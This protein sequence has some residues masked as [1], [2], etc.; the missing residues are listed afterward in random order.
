MR[1]LLLRPALRRPLTSVLLLTSWLAACGPDLQPNPDDVPD[2]E[3]PGNAPQESNIHHVDNGDGTFTTTLDATS[4]EKWIGFDLDQRQQV[5][6]TEDNQWDLAFQRFHIR[7]RG[8]V[9]GSG[10]V[11]VAI[12]EDTDFA[13]VSQAPAEGYVTDAVDGADE[14]TDPDTAFESGTAWYSYDP[15]THQ[16]SPR[17]L[18][19]VVR[20]DEGAYF[21]VR[22]QS[23]YD[24][25][26]NPAMFQLHWGSVKP[27]PP[28]G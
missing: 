23:Y 1:A 22:I 7:V 20:T 11:A 25:A 6:G 8:G 12:L 21:K 19:Y 24:A 4:S 15:R 17:S 5:E 14:N 28:Q 3:D 2:I 10:A 26:G 13:Q 16:L 18:L 9:S 27:P